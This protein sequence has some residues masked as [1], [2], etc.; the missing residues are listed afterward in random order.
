MCKTGAGKCCHLSLEDNGIGMS[1][2]KRSELFNSAYQATK[3]DTEG[4]LGIGLGFSNSKE[5][6]EKNV[7]SIT[8]ERELGRGSKVTSRLPL[9]QLII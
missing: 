3:R 4:T 1:T 2:K 7:G 6:I 8:V 9:A 5:F